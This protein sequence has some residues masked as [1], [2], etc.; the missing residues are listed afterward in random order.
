VR[1]PKEIRPTDTCTR[2]GLRRATRVLEE[3]GVQIHLCD[4]CYWGT[5]PPE[6]A[7]PRQ[8]PAS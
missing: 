4:D 2:C 7:G 6:P 8:P 5:E 3:R 1:D